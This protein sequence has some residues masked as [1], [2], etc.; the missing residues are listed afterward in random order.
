MRPAF[1]DCLYRPLIN[2]PLMRHAVVQVV[3]HLGVA[4][5]RGHAA[6]VIVMVMAR[7]EQIDRVDPERLEL[8][9]DVGGSS[10]VDEGR[11]R[12]MASKGMLL[13]AN[14]VTYYAMKERAASLGMPPEMLEKNELVI[15][16]GLRS[17]EIC[18]RAG[19][20]VAYG[21]DL[22]GPLQAEQSR[23]FVLRAQVLSPME[24]IRSA[25]SVGARVLRREGKLGCLRP[26]ALADLL[27]VDGNPL[28]DIS[29]LQSPEK[30]LLA[31]MKGG[32]FY[33]NRLR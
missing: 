13:V 3:P 11:A 15:D 29:V 14:L 12:L 24:I 32:R 22:L 18:K 20:P 19:V 10:G 1:D 28:K 21:T 33:R 17:L 31:I 8:N 30:S 9:H 4:E 26:D 27:V 16:G 7:D 5:Y 25:T 2:G 6:D 23:E